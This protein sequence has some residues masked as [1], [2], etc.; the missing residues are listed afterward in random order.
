MC[1]YVELW[2][3]YKMRTILIFCTAQV[4]FNGRVGC[5]DE[6]QVTE[7]REGGHIVRQSLDPHWSMY[8]LDRR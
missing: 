1:L 4:Q 2:C 7:V 6:P 5:I 8:L 3:I